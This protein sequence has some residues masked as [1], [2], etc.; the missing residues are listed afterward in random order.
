MHAVRIYDQPYAVEDR[1]AD[2]GVTRNEMIDVIEQIVAARFS[3]VSV[4]ARAAAGQQA[5]LAGVRHTR[6][7]FMRRDWEPNCDNGV[8]SVYDPKSKTKIVYQSVDSACVSIRA[9][10]AINAKGKVSSDLVNS[11]QGCLFT[12]EELP[13]VAPSDIE[14]LNST[15]WYLCVSAEDDDIRAELS[16]PA[17][18]VNR[19]FKGFLERIFI[20]KAGEWDNRHQ[21]S[22][23][24]DDDDG[25]Y[26]FSIVRR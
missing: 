19:N 5:Y 11:A 21:P 8:E 17:A 10:Q 6:F 22:A 26:E 25:A 4:D 24:R 18:I 9:P 7:L 16:L 3:V 12:A 1:L 20:V 14:N 15:I 13:E 23:R 2:F